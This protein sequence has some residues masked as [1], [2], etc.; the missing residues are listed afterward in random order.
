MALAKIVVLFLI[1]L[2][3]PLADARTYVS[4]DLKFTKIYKQKC[5]VWANFQDRECLNLC[6]KDFPECHKNCNA[7]NDNTEVVDM[8]YC[9]DWTVWS[10]WTIGDC[11]CLQE[12]YR[13]FP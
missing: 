6:K 10:F 3:S 9:Q 8:G 2:I 12:V 13:V 4:M 1:V 11:K 5:S 7:Q